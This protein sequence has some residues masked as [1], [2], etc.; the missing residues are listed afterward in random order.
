MRRL[1]F[2]AMISSVLDAEFT[3]AARERRRRHFEHAAAD[4]S[5]RA[6]ALAV[7]AGP[8]AAPPEVFTPEHLARVLG[9]ETAA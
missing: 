6:H 9:M 7:M 5:L 2:A 4:P 1:R 8:E 3:D